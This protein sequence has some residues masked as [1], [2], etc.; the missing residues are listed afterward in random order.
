MKVKGNHL[1]ENNPDMNIG[2]IWRTVRHLNFDQWRYRFVRRGWYLIA[3]LFPNFWWGRFEYLCESVPLA[4]PCR[5]RFKSIADQVLVHQ[6]AVH[7]NRLQEMTEGKF[8]FLGVTLDFG[9]IHNFD[10]K[11]RLNTEDSLLWR[12]NLGYMGYAVP[13]LASGKP[14]D[15]ER[16]SALVRGLS[17]KNTWLM[18]GVFKDIWNPYTVSHRI[19]NL[20]T[21]LNLF[22]RAG[23]DM[24][25][26]DVRAIL[27]HCRFAVAY[28]LANLERDLQFNHLMKNYMALAVYGAA[29]ER[30][31]EHWG[32]FFTDAMVSIAQNFLGDG[33]HVERSPMYHHLA[34]RDLRIILDSG[35]VEGKA[36]NQLENYEHQ[37]TMAL[38][39]LSH[40][41]GDIAL[42][43]DSWLGEAPPSAITAPK[44]LNPG[45]Y[46]L[47]DMGYIRLDGGDDVAIM[48]VGPCGPDENP[49]H[50]H[51]DFLSVE[52]SIAGKRFLVDPGT[53]A[54][55]PGLARDKS[56][57]AAQHNGP[58]V[59][60]AEPIEFWHSFRVAR[61]GRAMPLEDL[62]GIA[63]MCAVG[64]QDGYEYLG[65]DVRR[66][67]ALW[68]GEALLIAD[69]W[70]G[71]AA[72][73]RAVSRFL[74]PADWQGEPGQPALFLLDG[75]SVHINVSIGMSGDVQPSE[76]WP[77][78]GSAVSANALSVAAAQLNDNHLFGLVIIFQWG[79]CPDVDGS[80]VL[81]RLKDLC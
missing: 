57:S 8:T 52:L 34:L 67:V 26:G 17:E 4:N 50:A 28:L 56:R 36:V 16:T 32:A 47:P 37:A 38:K 48:D 41:D 71:G 78:F 51:A 46:K 15:L 60:D 66:F 61:R 14:I 76:W 7:G 45:R 33:G 81:S 35:L 31:P 72:R 44:G 59:I 25:A 53:A 62:E 12:L 20:L 43:N 55:A 40:P 22:G 23:G 24:S 2:R 11:R 3:R 58:H 75:R 63:P 21:G 70:K 10:W 29:L 80:L 79:G 64:R 19:V 65:L 6:M 5:P 69:L 77:H 1:Y 73:E 68:P 54:Y 39:I 74:I 30:L 27:S 49:A 13:W 18:P 9:G 42:F